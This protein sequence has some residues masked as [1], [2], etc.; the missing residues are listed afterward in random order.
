[1]E[2]LIERYFSNGGRVNLKSFAEEIK[3]INKKE[4]LE[5]KKILR[6]EIDEIEEKLAQGKFLPDE[7]VYY[8]NKIWREKATVASSIKNRIIN[9]IQK[10]LIIRKFIKDKEKEKLY[11]QCLLDAMDWCL[12][13]DV[14]DNILKKADEYKRKPILEENLN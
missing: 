11:S 1:M 7:N 8:A 2:T 5:L 12:P 3:E 14:I 6:S 9:I 10:E 13:P 4:L